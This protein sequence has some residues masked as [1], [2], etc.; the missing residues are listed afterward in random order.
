MLPPA[1]AQLPPFDQEWRWVHFTTESGLPSDNIYNVVET[2]DGTPWVATSRGVAW[3]DGYRWNTVDTSLVLPV[4]RTNAF[5]AL[6]DDRILLVTRGKAF[7]GGKTGFRS[8]VTGHVEH[9]IPFSSDSIL[10]TSREELFLASRDTLIPMM[11]GEKVHDMW[12]TAS[13]TVWVNSNEALFKW[14]GGGWA[15]QMRWSTTMLKSQRHVLLENSDG[16]GLVSISLPFDAWGIWEWDRGRKPRLA[17]ETKGFSLKSAAMNSK[18]WI[19]AIHESGSARLR[20]YDKWEPV[21]FRQP[22]V[23]DI[24]FVGYRKND[25]LWIGTQR[26]LFLF[27]ETSRR[28]TY[29]QYEFPDPRNSINEII[30]TRDGS[31]WIASAKGIEIRKPNGT[32]K[33]IYKI[34]GVHL[35][36]VTG[37][38][39][40]RDGNVWISSGGGFDGAF[41]WD[42]KQW[43]RF[44]RGTPLEGNKVHKIRMDSE[45][46][47]WFL[48]IWPVFPLTDSTVLLGAYVY[49]NGKFESH[50]GEK[51][52][53]PS[54]KVYAFAEGRDGALWFGTFAGLARLKGGDWTYWRSPASKNPSG[55]DRIFA[56]C[57]GN[58]D[59]VWF[60]TQS[61]G[62]AYIDDRDSIHWFSIADGLVNNEVW[63]LRVDDRGRIWAATSGG[64]SHYDNDIWTSIDS[65]TGL[66][67][68]ELWPVLPTEDKVYVGT[69][70]R[71]V[72]ILDRSTEQLPAPKIVIEQPT[73]HASSAVVLWSVFAYWGDPASSSILTRYRL[74]TGRWSSWNTKRTV[75]IDNLSPGVYSIQM[76]AISPFGVFDPAG[77]SASFEIVAPLYRQPIVLVLAGGL[78]G[79]VLTFGGVL[80]NRKV[81]YDAELRASESK[82]RAISETTSS[83]LLIYNEHKVLF[84]NPSAEVLTGFSADELLKDSI[85]NIVHPDSREE[86]RQQSLLFRRHDEGTRRAELKILKKGGEECWIDYSEG[87]LNFNGKQAIVGTGFDVTER[88]KAEE[89]ILANQHQLRSLAAELSVTEERERRS[90]ATTLHDSVGQALAVCKIKLGLLQKTASTD[91]PADAMNEIRSLIETAIY[92]TR[93]LTF[94][95]SPP[96]LHELGLVATLDWL[97]EQ[98][99]TQ[100]NISVSVDADKSKLPLTDEIRTLMFHSVRELLLNVAKH[101]KAKNVIISVGIRQHHLHVSVSDDG[102]GQDL[103]Q[104][105]EGRLRNQGFGLFNIRE[106]F[107]QIGGRMEIVSSKGSGTSVELILPI[108]KQNA[109][110]SQGIRV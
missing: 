85:F 87:R 78:V 2:S 3:F 91:G 62:V 95:L 60:S 74:N 12:Q 13:G 41:R 64:L 101:A 88:K 71:G 23:R 45:G 68:A 48:A 86:F 70:G 77:A 24:E 27:R 94:E 97:A 33:T 99:H 47:L 1:H 92:H 80:Y 89:K 30:K 65:R 25:D 38:I 22:Q 58:D 59:K 17:P 96:T 66:S 98:F 52:G 37:L 93:T 73:T 35:Y 28:W 72:S 46:R 6:P 4:G 109:I 75:T 31:L 103:K 53:L 39:E 7:I 55:V 83:A 19:L 76:Q 110:Q 63:D 50:W 8:I 100:H 5:Y 49:A 20:Q 102:V 69:R 54:R 56:L 61:H 14:D 36:V 11:P 34:L 44:A 42:G 90:L 16:R 82:F 84:V 67:G 106:R 104:E 26:G 10:L 105:R 57:I 108:Q 9:A 43:Q 15:E 32:V 40:D 79:L 81:R 29:L 18:G 107:A 21:D 51:E